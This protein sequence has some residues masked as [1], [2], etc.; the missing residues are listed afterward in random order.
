MEVH[1]AADRSGAYRRAGPT[2]RDS[3]YFQGNMRYTFENIGRYMQL[4][5]QLLTHH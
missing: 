3:L 4:L 1:I 2:K 5:T